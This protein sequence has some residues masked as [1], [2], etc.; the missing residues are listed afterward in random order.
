M[1]YLL[2]MKQYNN[3]GYYITENGEV[4]NSK[5]KKLKPR[6]NR[7]YSSVVLYI[8]GDSKV[9]KIHR[10]V[11]ETYIPNPD[12]K[13]QVNHINGVK[14]DNR[15]E[16]LEWVTPSQNQK[17]RFNVLNHKTLNG[18]NHSKSKLTEEQ[19]KWIRNLY[20]PR[21]RDYG[22]NAFARLFN[23][24]QSTIHDI[25]HNKIWSHLE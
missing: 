4:Y 6:N 11:A 23:V 5:G 21:D 15:I 18:E 22:Q 25:I 10:L 24:K 20:I 17:H 2:Y 1:L 14:T 7:G 8:D 12:N 13:P 16:N 3:S 9:K 19:V